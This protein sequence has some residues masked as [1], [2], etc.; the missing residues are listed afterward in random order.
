M[1]YP[2]ARDGS[3]LA[4]TKRISP[5]PI[6]TNPPTFPG[7]R[8]NVPQPYRARHHDFQ[9]K[10]DQCLAQNWLR[11]S[12]LTARPLTL[13][14][15]RHLPHKGVR[16]PRDNC[17]GVHPFIFCWISPTFPRP[18]KNEQ[19]IVL[20]LDRV[21][22]L[23]SPNLFPVIK[24]VDRNQTASFLECLPVGRCGVHSFDPR[25]D[26]FVR[27]FGI[28]GPMRLNSLA[29]GASAAEYA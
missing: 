26:G 5:P 2:F 27:D 23:P 15:L 29:T 20:H 3:P 17:A 4:R 25:V 21:R 13:C 24:S 22:N 8:L 28:F 6:S 16:L 12:V 7:S 18:G 14:G 9:I 11:L 10:V 19:T 1:R